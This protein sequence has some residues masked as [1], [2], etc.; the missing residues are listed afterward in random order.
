M[1]QWKTRCKKDVTL[2][3]RRR[4]WESRCGIYKVIESVCLYG[5]KEGPQ[6]I[7]TIY[8]AMHRRELGWYILSRHR[9]RSAAVTAC[10]KHAKA[11]I[12]GPRKRKRRTQKD[13]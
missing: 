7:P 1:I 13:H 11:E 8:Y 12:N 2:T 9:K 4:H 6:A 5:P 10:E 3:S